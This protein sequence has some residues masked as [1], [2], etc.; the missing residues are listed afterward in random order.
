MFSL[1]LVCG[2]NVCLVQLQ[3]MHD[4]QENVRQ[5]NWQLVFSRLFNLKKKRVS[6][7]QGR[8]LL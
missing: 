2:I 3:N 4:M 8:V 1:S 6:F 7:T 5:S